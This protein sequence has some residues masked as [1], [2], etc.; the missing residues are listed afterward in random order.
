MNYTT[1]I[2]L[3]KTVILEDQQ[4]LAVKMEDLFAELTQL[5][6][7]MN[8]TERLELVECVHL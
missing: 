5:Y 3:T 7:L 1:E 2:S 6:T 8:H 4:K